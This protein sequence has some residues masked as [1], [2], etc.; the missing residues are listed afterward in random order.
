[1]KSKEQVAKLKGALSKVDGLKVDIA[2]KRDE[3]REAV[4]E[5]EAILE[6][7]D[8]AVDSLEAGA[9]EFDRAIEALSAYL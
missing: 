6:S 7:M 9:R 5:V 3:L 4:G 2:K 8:E 1:M